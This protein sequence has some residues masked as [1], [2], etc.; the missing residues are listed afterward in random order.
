M[1]SSFN[2]KSDWSTFELSGGETSV[3]I[4]EAAG[5]TSGTAGSTSGT[6]GGGINSV[7]IS[8]AD[9][10]ASGTTGDG[11]ALLLLGKTDDKISN[12]SSPSDIFESAST[13]GTC[14]GIFWSVLDRLELTSCEERVRN[15]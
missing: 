6:T 7:L 5:L 2:C 14:T 4:C 1:D 13:S 11:K 10:C 8:E 3:S 15:E 9:G 12:A